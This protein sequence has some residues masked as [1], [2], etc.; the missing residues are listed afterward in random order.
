MLFSWSD[1]RLVELAR[2]VRMGLITGSDGYYKL[3]MGVAVHRL[4]ILGVS[5][6][7]PGIFDGNL[8]WVVLAVVASGVV[9]RAW[10]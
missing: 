4:V 7:M 9:H 2:R 3:M 6:I 8:L 1:W 5:C 10:N